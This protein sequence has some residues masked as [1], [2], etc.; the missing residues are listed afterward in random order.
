[1]AI[2]ARRDASCV[3]CITLDLQE[4]VRLLRL[5]GGSVGEQATSQDQQKLLSSCLDDLPELSIASGHLLEDD[6]SLQGPNQV[7]TIIAGGK[8]VDGDQVS[9]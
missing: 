7:C 2:Y 4:M 3:T 6:A 9:I 8:E 1:M 5:I